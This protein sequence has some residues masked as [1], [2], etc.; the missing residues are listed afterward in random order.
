MPDHKLV[1]RRLPPSMDELEFI[2]Q[3]SPLPEHDYYCFFEASSGLGPHSFS[4][5]Y[6]NFLDSVDMSL[7]KERFDNYVFLDKNGHEYPAVVEESLWHK[8][9]KSGPFYKN[10]NEANTT[11]DK[12][13]NGSIEEDPDYLEF[14]ENLRTQKKRAQQSPIQILESNLDELTSSNHSSPISNNLQSA[15]NS[16]ETINNSSSSSGGN[17][18]KSSLKHQNKVTTP[19]IGYV[20]QQ[21]SLKQHGFNSNKKRTK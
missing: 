16:S 13:S 7:F 5:A 2:K 12:I 9:P 15:Q 20:N 14:I 17:I 21:R 4:R 11:S 18:S 19:L 8:S 1:I 10:Q 6:I 3:V